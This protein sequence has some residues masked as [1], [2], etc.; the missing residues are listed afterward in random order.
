MTQQICEK[1]SST[2]LPGER[3]CGTCLDDPTPPNVRLAV[4]EREA[5]TRRW[6][7]TAYRKTR[8][9]RK[10]ALEE[11][12]AAVKSGSAIISKQ[13]EEMLAYVFD[14][15]PLLQRFKVSPFSAE[16]MRHETR[17]QKVKTE[18]DNKVYPGLSYKITSAVLSLT[19]EGLPVF[20]SYHLKIDE[21][22]LTDRAT[23][24]EY[25]TVRLFQ[26]PEE[27][28][29]EDWREQNWSATTGRVAFWAHVHVLASAKLH[30]KLKATHTAA[31][32]RR[33]VLSEGMAF[34]ETDYLEIHIYGDVERES[35]RS[36]KPPAHISEADRPYITLINGWLSH[37]ELSTHRDS[38]LGT[39]PDARR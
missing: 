9:E 6:S 23:V 15:L 4:A 17:A 2:V 8:Q 29:V 35:I 22:V 10:F 7:S 5:L 20:G 39:G 24:L 18:A 34:L 38:V 27:D 26:Q 1:C 3:L 11:F 32:F 21:T 37:F 14:D 28:D 16:S 12:T 19:D 33:I 25:G 30:S 31:D 13:P 36:V